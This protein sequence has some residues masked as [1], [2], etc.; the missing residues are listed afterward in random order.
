MLGYKINPAY[1]HAAVQNAVYEEL[2][3]D[4]G[5]FA[6]IPGFDGVWASAETEE[7]CKAELESVLEGWLELSMEQ[8]MPVPALDGLRVT[9]H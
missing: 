8:D 9:V 1:V 2:P 4:E 3:E 7:A 6:S 5:I